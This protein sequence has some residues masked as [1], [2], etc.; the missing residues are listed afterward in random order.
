MKINYLPVIILILTS[1]TIRSQSNNNNSYCHIYPPSITNASLDLNE[2][3]LKGE[4]KSIK[5]LSHYSGE[6]ESLNYMEFNE[7]GYLTLDII[8]G[9][10]ESKNGGLTIAKDVKLKSDG[11]ISRYIYEFENGTIKSLTSYDTIFEIESKRKMVIGNIDTK[12]HVYTYNE[13]GTLAN[14]KK[15]MH[16][17]DTTIANKK[18]P[19]EVFTIFYENNKILKAVLQESYW[20]RKASSSIKTKTIEYN[21][22]GAKTILKESTEG[23]NIYTYLHCK[24]EETVLKSKYE[25][26]VFKYEPSGILKSQ[27]ITYYDGETKNTSWSF[28]DKN[29][30]IERVSEL[31]PKIKFSYTFDQ[32][33][34]WISKK[35][36]SSIT[37]EAVEEYNRTIE[38][39]N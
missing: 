7:K 18:E 27:N 30:P 31:G 34:N 37:G 3:Q 24:L 38:Y 13:N 26:T 28:D 2:Y 17:T 12:K 14:Y 33:G 36:I 16:S 15:Y 11:I 22:D 1:C 21:Y 32:Q 20:S 9:P 25:T 35:V 39:Y 19:Y 23:G 29:N 10:Y 6:D 5:E 4:V 8:D